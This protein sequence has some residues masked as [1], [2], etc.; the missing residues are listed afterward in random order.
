MYDGK[1]K[2]EI[3]RQRGR[4]LP[5]NRNQKNGKNK[6]YDQYG[7][8]VDEYGRPVDKYGRAYADYDKDGNPPPLPRRSPTP[9]RKPSG[10]TNAL[11]KGTGAPRKGTGVPR[12][13]ANGTKSRSPARPP[14]NG[15]KK[16]KR[17]RIPVL[18]IVAVLLVAVLALA[19]WDVNHLLGLYQYDDTNESSLS[20]N[21]QDGVMTVALFGVDTRAEGDGGT[22]S[23][24]IMIM[25]VDPARK[26]VKLIS[27]MRDSYIEVPGHGKTKLCH[28]YGYGGPQLMME[29]INKNFDMNITEY[30]TVDFA[31]MASIIDAV[32]GV[33]VTLTDEELTET[34]KYIREYCTENGIDDQPIE[35]A[36]EQQLNGIQAMTYGRIRKGNTGGDWSRTERQSTVL[37]QVFSKATGNPVALLRFLHGLMPNI[38]S[39][40][41]KSD[42]WYMGLHTIVHGMPSMDHLRLPLDGEWQYGTTDSGMSVVKFNDA[43]LAQHLRDY[44]YKDITP[45]AL[46]NGNTN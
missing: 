18:R 1:D 5:V 25:S 12:S 29:T 4:E 9:R 16:K 37:N 34:N 36:G 43:V 14:Q 21:T 19:V 44:I 28:A 39:S 32:G 31:Q 3:P 7:Q 41:S 27:L 42:F 33:T 2:D 30:M 40:M 46:T 17:R 26:S 13:S 24:A 8:P 20:E 23:D 11:R 35:A 38:T 10:S 6:Y 15:R 45:T 22:R